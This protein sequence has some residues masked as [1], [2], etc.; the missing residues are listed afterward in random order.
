MGVQVFVLG[1]ANDFAGVV[2][3]ARERTEEAEGYRAVGH[4]LQVFAVD[5]DG[6][7][8]LRAA[9]RD[10]NGRAVAEPDVIRA[11]QT[12]AHEYARSAFANAGIVR[13]S[14]RNGEI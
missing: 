13:R 7:A 2:T 9:G 1:E 11:R 8:F 4:E 14:A 6:V 5:F 12:A 3:G 10:A